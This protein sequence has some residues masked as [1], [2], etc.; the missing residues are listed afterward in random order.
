MDN[1]ID[2][3]EFH[4]KEEHEDSALNVTAGVESQPVVNP[5]FKRVKR[6]TL[7]TDDYGKGILEGN[8]TIL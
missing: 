4:H 3:Y 7:T 8:I 6:R 1:N 2:H 5:Y